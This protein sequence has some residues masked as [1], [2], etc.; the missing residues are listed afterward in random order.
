[1]MKALMTPRL[2]SRDSGGLKILPSLLWYTA[3]SSSSA[4]TK[5]K[6]IQIRTNVIVVLESLPIDSIP[7]GVIIRFQTKPLK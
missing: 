4:C 5:K 3:A 2:E 6:P 1:M 7:P